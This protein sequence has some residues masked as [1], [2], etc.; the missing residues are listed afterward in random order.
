MYFKGRMPNSQESLSSTIPRDSP[1]MD[2]L[3]PTPPSTDSEGNQNVILN[4]FHQWVYYEGGPCHICNYPETSPETDLYIGPQPQLPKVNCQPTRSSLG[5]SPVLNNQEKH[6]HDM[7]ILH[8][9][10]YSMATLGLLLSPV[11]EMIE[12]TTPPKYPAHFGRLRLFG[13]PIPFP[14]LEEQFEEDQSKNVETEE[15]D[16]L[17]STFMI[18]LISQQ[19]RH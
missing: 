8:L 3:L 19:D 13:D 9:R 17:K 7:H 6:G 15:P 2:V 12:E 1:N 18:R 11:Q 10:R 14:R 5:A 4:E 16:H